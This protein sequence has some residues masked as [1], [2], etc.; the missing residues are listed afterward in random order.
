[1]RL[2]TSTR[3]DYTIHVNNIN[4]NAKTM[5]GQYKD[6]SRGLSIGAEKIPYNLSLS[7]LLR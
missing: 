2:D 4:L 3:P 7:N 1:M 5:Q 6:V